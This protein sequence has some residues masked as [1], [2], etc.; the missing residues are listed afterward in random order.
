MIVPPPKALPSSIH[1]TRI[2]PEELGGGYG[3]DMLF[4]NL[5]SKSMN[6]GVAYDEVNKWP[7]GIIPYDISAITN[8]DDRQI[9]ETAMQ[10][11]MYNTGSPIA[12]STSRHVCVYFRPKKTDD[13]TF[14]TIVYGQG[15]SAHIGYYPNYPL[16]MT[17]QKDDSANCFDSGTIQHEILHVIG[18]RHEHQRPDRDNYIQINYDNID[19]E[20]HNDFAKQTWGTSAVDLKTSYDY[21]SIMHY[22]ENYFSVNG[23][24][25]IVP[26]QGN[27]PIGSRTMLSPT[28]VKEV[29]L[30][31]GCEA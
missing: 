15:C 24:P 2:S 20:K 12:N 25:T 18:F 19:P 30:F 7:S 1:H 6:R 13:S 21:S 11:L 4:P 29:R 17:L 16:K 27:A 8:A 23:K 14:L 26:K 10:Y 5:P 22:G 31:Y 3:G 28:D 9:I